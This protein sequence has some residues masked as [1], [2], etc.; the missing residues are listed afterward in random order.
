MTR[1]QAE[2]EAICRP[3]RIRSQGRGTHSGETG[4]EAFVS[5]KQHLR[6]QRPMEVKKH[7]R[8]SQGKYESRVLNPMLS[9]STATN[10]FQFAAKEEGWVANLGAG[11]LEEA[12]KRVEGIGRRASCN[13]TMSQSDSGMTQGLEGRGNQGTEVEILG[14]DEGLRGRGRR[15]TDQGLQNQAALNHDSSMNIEGGGDVRNTVMQTPTEIG[16][17]LLPAAGLA[18]P[19]TVSPTYTVGSRHSETRDFR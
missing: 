6:I 4:G 17:K 12:M 9:S 14:G 15:T 13:H 18:V 1:V 5:L 10:H 11:V 19:M 2:G 7:F 16:A 8:S 3:R